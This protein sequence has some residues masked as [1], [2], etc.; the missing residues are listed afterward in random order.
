MFVGVILTGD[1]FQAKG[2]ISRAG[3]T[4]LRLPLCE[5]VYLSALHL[6]RLFPKAFPILCITMD[7]NSYD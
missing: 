7:C 6:Q 4:R 3:S 1:A 5:I 2:R